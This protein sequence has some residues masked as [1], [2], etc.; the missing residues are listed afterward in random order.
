LTHHPLFWCSC[1]GNLRHPG[2]MCIDT[3]PEMLSSSLAWLPQMKAA[4]GLS[5]LKW[6]SNIWG[7]QCLA[8]SILIMNSSPC[9]LLLSRRDFEECQVHNKH[10]AG[11]P[12]SE[13]ICVLFFNVWL[14]PVPDKVLKKNS[15][16]PE[17]W[18][19]LRGSS[20]SEALKP[21]F[22]RPVVFVPLRC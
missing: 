12:C 17:Q 5:I 6:Y 8:L 20:D 7:H 11:I 4:F 16:L 14:S 10:C 21:T 1:T 19:R 18:R 13:I 9:V 2:H 15:R 22:A 3:S